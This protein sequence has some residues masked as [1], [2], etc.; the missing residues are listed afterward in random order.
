MRL[1]VL[2]G[3]ISAFTG[4]QSAAQVPITLDWART[5]SPDEIRVRV[6]GPLAPLYRD[7]SEPLT[8][9]GTGGALSELRMA[10]TPFSA[11][12]GVC[13]SD[14]VSVQFD[15]VVPVPDWP[16]PSGLEGAPVRPLKL[17]TEARFAIS[18]DAQPIWGDSSS[19]YEPAD[20]AC[21]KLGNGWNFIEADHRGSVADGGRLFRLLRNDAANDP[22]ALETLIQ[23]CEG[24]LCGAAVTFLAGL[25]YSELSHASEFPCDGFSYTPVDRPLHYPTCLALTLQGERIGEDKVL[26]LYAKQEWSEVDRAYTFSGVSLNHRRTPHLFFGC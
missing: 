15:L 22:A 11:F 14:V 3:V 9:P 21:A 2:I 19:D 7:V 18:D 8:I 20:V 13:E 5:A 23:Y 1:T 25:A 17:T 24:D 10:S 6:L 16:P 26:C 4:T 12:P